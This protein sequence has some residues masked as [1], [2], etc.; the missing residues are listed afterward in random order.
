MV[1]YMDVVQLPFR[2]NEVVISCGRAFS[3]CLSLSKWKQYTTRACDLSKN[4]KRACNV[5]FLS[6]IYIAVDT[7]FK[8]A[9]ML[10]Y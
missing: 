8:L 2:G 6:L 3:Q 9:V 1:R 4:I 10:L 5:S 7:L